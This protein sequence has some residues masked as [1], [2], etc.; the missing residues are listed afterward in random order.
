MALLFRPSAPHPRQFMPELMFREIWMELDRTGYRRALKGDEGM[1]TRFRASSEQEKLTSK[2]LGTAEHLEQL[3]K[4]AHFRQPVR[5][6]CLG[7][8]DL[9][10]GLANTTNN[11]M[12][13]LVVFRLILEAF[14]IDLDRAE[15]YDPIIE[16]RLRA[17]LNG[18]GFS[19]VLHSE[20]QSWKSMVADEPTFIFMPHVYG[21]IMINTLFFNM[22]SFR[23]SNLLFLSTTFNNAVEPA[24][25][26]KYMR[27]T[28]IAPPNAD[29][30]AKCRSG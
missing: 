14:G 15:I 5:A 29:F 12:G 11:S 19:N 28:W 17:F 10:L 7:I 8:G 9:G 26:N 6:L 20:R 16:D 18:I 23:L 24:A 1:E 25:A 27:S 4:D 13:Q 21:D 30:L 2:A 3:V 22:D